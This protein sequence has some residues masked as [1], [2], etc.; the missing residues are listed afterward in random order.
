MRF[1]YI[2]L[3]LSITSPS[4]IAQIVNI[5]D[6]N[7]KFTLVNNNVV[8]IDGDFIGD[9]DVDTNNDGEIQVTE[10]EAVLVLNLNGRLGGVSSIQGI[11]SF[12]NVTWLDAS[13]SGLLTLVDISQLVN[14]ESLSIRSCE[15]TNLDVTH[16]INLKYIDCGFNMLTSLNISQ[17]ILLEELR[18]YS[19]GFGTNVLDVSNNPYLHTLY[20]S[21][22]GLDAIDVSQNTNLEILDLWNNQVNSLDVSQNLKL[23]ELQLEGN[24]LTSLDISQNTLLEELS[25]WSNEITS[26]DVS[27]N[28]NLIRLYAGYNNLTFLNVAN[29]NNTNMISMFAQNNDNLTCIQV[30]DETVFY[31][32][33]NYSGST[34]WCREPFSAYRNICI[35]DTI[36]PI[37]VTQDV[38]ATLDE[39]GIVVILPLNVNN[40]STDNVTWQANLVFSLNKDT[41]NCDDLGPNTVILTVTDQAGNSAS[42][43]A[44]VSIIDDISPTVITQ[45]IEAILNNNGEVSISASEVDNGSSDNCNIATMEIDITD[46]T[47]SNLGSN[48]VTLIITDAAG[49]SEQNTAVV[50]VLDNQPPNVI[51]QN[52]TRDLNGGTSVSIVPSEVDNGT[53]DNCNFT[54]SL[55]QTIFTSPGSYSITLFAEDNAGNMDS[56]SAVVTI[57]DST[58]GMSENPELYFSLSPNPTKGTFKLILKE[59]MEVQQ[60]RFVDINGRTIPINYIVEIDGSLS[61]DIGTLPPA[62]YFLLIETKKGVGKA[63]VIVH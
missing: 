63:R 49:N 61:V 10:A 50:N 32:A 29:G 37:V 43:N 16:N 3:F 31:P 47:C 6:A 11:E 13:N 52:I 45:N 7:F 2:V 14:L 23:V 34:G 8:D 4:L 1:I 24:N 51:T 58:L 19:M 39:N 59:R 55:D 9:I 18:C 17:N 38:D 36:P 46:F 56:A 5:P 44:I 60:L 21:A 41:F 27:S 42:E 35:P 22:L 57:I 15:L 62:I 48:T 28:T 30:D 12:V 33:C 25:V 54:L 53:T 26:L 20:L 40:G